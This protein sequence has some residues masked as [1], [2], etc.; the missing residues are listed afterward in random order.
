MNANFGAMEKRKKIVLIIAIFASIILYFAGVFSGI[1]ITRVYRAETKE[2]I[3][4]IE[5]YV[6]SVRESVED[7][8]VQQTFF[9]I[10][11]ETDKIGRAHV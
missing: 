11:G 9:N 7:I 4:I 3:G 8:Q 5:D 10:L 6:T 1:F 2:D